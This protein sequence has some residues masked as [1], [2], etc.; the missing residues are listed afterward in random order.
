[1]VRLCSVHVQK[2][3]AT[4]CSKMDL[5]WTTENRQTTGHLEKKD[6]KRNEGGWKDLDHPIQFWFG[7]NVWTH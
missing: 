4:Y 5:T 7:R 1:M 3:P 2:Y 6:W